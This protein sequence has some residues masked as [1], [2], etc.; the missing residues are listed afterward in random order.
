M[1]AYDRASATYTMI[2]ALLTDVKWIMTKTPL[3]PGM[4]I[5]MFTFLTIRLMHQFEIAGGELRRLVVRGNHN[6]ESVLQL[7][8]LERNGARLDE[9]V[10]DT[11]AYL[12]VTTPM[13][14]SSHVVS[15][16]RV[17][18]GKRDTLAALLD[19]HVHGGSPRRRAI[20]RDR[21][22]EHAAL[23]A[24]SGLS[25]QDVVLFDYE[26]QVELLPLEPRR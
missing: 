2:D 25:T 12:S 6:V 16:V 18:G 14:Q 13:I 19:W 11:R 21:R 5:P 10:R 24:S 1:Q 7:A 15:D 20:A 17:H 4:G 26:V 3:V 9:A 23:L 8:L 22:A